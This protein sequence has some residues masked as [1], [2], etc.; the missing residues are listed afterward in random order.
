[1]LNTEKDY[2]ETLDFLYSFVDYSLTRQLR[3]SPDKFNLDRMHLF[4]EKL[5]NP[6]YSY[7]VIHIAGTKG[8]GSTAVFISSVLQKAGF[9]VGL[10]TSPHLHDYT[11]RIQVNR[12]PIRHQELT[13]Q[14]NFIKEHVSLIPEITTFEI[15]TAIAF[16]YFAETKVDIA[17]IE[18]GLGGRLDATNVV[19]PEISVITSLSYDHMNVLGDTIEK[20]AAEKGG[21]I[22]KNK[23]VIV[24][25]Q[26]FSQSY[27]VLQDIAYERNSPYIQ[28]D[29]KID[30]IPLDHDFDSQQFLIKKADGENHDQKLTIP[31]LG[32][33]QVENAVTAWCAL[34]ELNTKGY[35]ISDDDIKLGFSTAEW[36]CR[37]EIVN[38]DRLVIIDSAHNADSAK[39]LSA[40]AIEYLGDRKITLIFG[41]S[42]D[43]DVNGMFESLLPISDDIIM[44][45]SIHPRAMAPE[46]LKTIAR[47][48]GR[49]SFV[50]ENLEDALRLTLSRKNENVVI[51]TGSIFIAAAAKEIIQKGI[52]N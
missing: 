2:Q 22:K 30:F 35:G 42:E 44:T 29:K 34:K 1:M 36:P 26:T 15:T 31:L 39:K 16:N 17:V 40:T 23:P 24:A 7:P 9:S 3:F 19:D 18:V 6:Q 37:F 27:K 4:T 43:K 47:D 45:K 33:H 38:L 28:V 14:V 49:D 20:I 51:V 10:Y 25:P 12:I 50:A 46:K 32:H 13:D 11:E 41:A 5:G 21:I 52:S 8:K 48:L